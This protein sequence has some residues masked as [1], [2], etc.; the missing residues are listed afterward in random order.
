MNISFYN[1]LEKCKDTKSS[2]SLD[3]AIQNLDLDEK[4]RNNLKLLLW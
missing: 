3:F 4:R 1:E 2:R